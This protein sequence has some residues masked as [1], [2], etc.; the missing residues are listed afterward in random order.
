MAAE[1]WGENFKEL[2]ANCAEEMGNAA[3]AESISLPRLG[4]RDMG[5][6]HNNRAGTIRLLHGL[7]GVARTGGSSSSVVQ[8]TAA[9]DCKYYF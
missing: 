9:V 4:Y 2:C 5:N 8:L 3:L 7:A 1:L 6:H